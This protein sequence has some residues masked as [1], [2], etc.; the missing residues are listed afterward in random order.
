L[1]YKLKLT[2]ILPF[3]P[4]KPVGGA[5]VV[6]E[7]A[8]RLADKGH[9]VVVLHSLKRPFKKN[10]SP[11]WWKRLVFKLR[12]VERPNWFALDKAVESRIVPEISDK[13]VPDGD[14]VIST[15]WQ[16]AYALDKIIDSKGRKFN[17]I[18]DYE[19][20]ENQQELVHQSYRLPLAHLVIARYLGKLVHR[21]SGREPLYLPNAIDGRQFFVSRSIDSRK[22]E[23]VIMLYSDE[24]RK[25]SKIGLDALVKVKADFPGLTATLF[26]VG[27]KP[28]DLPDWVTYYK[29]P[30]TLRELYNDHA[31]MIS[32]SLGE[33]W[34]L[35]PAEA[36]ACGC[37]VVCTDIG[38]HADYAKHQETALLVEPGNAIA[39]AEKLSILLM[40]PEK[41]IELAYA[42]N[43]FVT[44]N[45]S[46]EKSVV[47]LEGYCRD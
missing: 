43:S 9:Q 8:N 11:L 44:N 30:T 2:F 36:M 46:W 42:G 29:R 3:P 24:S 45:F 39:L 34:A 17:L 18:Q 25:G 21:Y 22:P 47:L 41:R 31:I 14:A 20:W 28:E 13:Y 33:G 16:M 5:K 15:W 37:A 1:E 38:G 10:K 40:R 32:P 19:I 35:P 7:Y 6:Y 4:T 12:K 23:S 26:G 27:E